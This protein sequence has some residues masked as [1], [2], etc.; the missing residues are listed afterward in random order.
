[1]KNFKTYN[2]EEAERNIKVE[3]E[4]FLQKIVPLLRRIQRFAALPICFMGIKWDQCRKKKISV[5]FDLLYIYFF[6]KDYPD[7][8]MQCR[9]FEK[10]KNLWTYYYGSG[11]NPLQRKHLSKNVWIKKYQII[12]NDKRITQQLCKASSLPT[13]RII[14]LITTK[15]ELWSI[16]E[17]FQN[18]NYENGYIIKPIDGSAGKGIF[19]II[20]VEDKFKLTNKGK[21]IPTDSFKIVSQYIIQECVTQHNQMGFF[22]NS[23]IN[24]IRVVTMLRSDKQVMIVGAYARFGR[25]DSVT[26]NVS[27]G[28]IGVGIMTLTGSL[29]KHGWDKYG[30]KYEVHPDSGLVFENFKIPHWENVVKLALET[31]SAF[32]FYRMVGIDFAICTDG[33]VIIEINAQPDLVALEQRNG[34]LLND[35]KI[36]KE[37][38]KQRLLYNNKQHKLY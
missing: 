24:T 25:A 1:M 35:Y 31:Q 21:A 5:I 8:Y 33:P 23:S 37:F 12:F 34:P 3:L 10:N 28:G 2:Y 29:R 30:R 17:G 18:E 13:P 22:N 19:K 32:S 4:R 9:L 20:K 14:G 26:D 15:E 6:L 7:N 16:L 38:K 27:D 36:W 11:Y